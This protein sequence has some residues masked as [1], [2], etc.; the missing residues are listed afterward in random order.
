MQK[1]TKLFD[2][3]FTSF[4][5]VRS[6]ITNEDKSDKFQYKIYYTGIEI[7]E[8]FPSNKLIQKPLTQP[9]NRLAY[10]LLWL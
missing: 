2:H 8:T 6:F 9:P 5:G 4:V 3:D 7:S 10:I 1:K